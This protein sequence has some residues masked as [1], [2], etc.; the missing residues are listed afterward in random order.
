[1]KKTTYYVTASDPFDRHQYDPFFSKGIRRP[2]RGG[3]GRGRPPREME[4]RPR[5]EA[6]GIRH[7]YA[8]R[9]GDS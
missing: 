6:S 7:L 2:R 9:S 5:P 1:M 4:G 8:S 3:G